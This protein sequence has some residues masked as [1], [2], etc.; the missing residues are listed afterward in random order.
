MVH[1]GRDVV[2]LGLDVVHLGW[3]QKAWNLSCA[4]LEELA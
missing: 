1:L 4:Q 2:H 3:V